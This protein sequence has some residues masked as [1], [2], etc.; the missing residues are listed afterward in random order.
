V[1]ETQQRNYTLQ[2]DGSFT[3]TG[4]RYGAAGWTGRLEGRDLAGTPLADWPGVPAG[5]PGNFP[6]GAQTL[7]LQG[8]MT[9]PRWRL[10]ES[11][12]NITLAGYVGLRLT[13]TD[14]QLPT[15]TLQVRT[16]NPAALA[17]TFDAALADQG[18]VTVWRLVNGALQRL[19]SGHY[20]VSTVHGQELLTVDSLDAEV[21][22]A[23]D[24]D[25]LARYQRGERHIAAW[26]SARLRTGSY[27]PAGPDTDQMPRLNRTAIDAVL[28]ALGLGTPTKPASPVPGDKVYVGTPS[29]PGTIFIPGDSVTP[30]TGSG[31]VISAGGTLGNTSVGRGTVT[32][33]SG[34]V[35]GYVI[36]TGGSIG[37]SGGGTPI[38][39]IDA[40]RPS[41]GSN[42]GTSAVGP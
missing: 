20:S 9:A 12:T 36:S 31:G 35:G 25:S 10:T 17:Y 7:A 16:D 29:T 1:A 40:S 30:G 18:S 37:L 21:Q 26:A 38:T 39:V 2:A 6:A 42:P 32:G 34:S 22:A 41:G 13:P 11:S 14:A 24:A 27:L 15:L 4:G 19:G 8:E 3:L 5:T 33:A 23:L 28:T